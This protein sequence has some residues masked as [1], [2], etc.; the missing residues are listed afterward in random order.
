MSCNKF[1]TPKEWTVISPEV[2]VTFRNA[3]KAKLD[4]FMSFVD[5]DP[6]TCRKTNLRSFVP[7][8]MSWWVDRPQLKLNVV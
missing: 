8:G 7:S 3:M 6:L 1:D 2:R 4:L 5:E